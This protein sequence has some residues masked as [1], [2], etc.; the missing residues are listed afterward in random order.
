MKNNQPVNNTERTFSND[1][2]LISTTDLKGQIT[3]VNDAFVEVSGFTR[4]ELIGKPH[5][6]V[7]HP[8]V[9]PA[10]FGDLWE[11]MKA[12]KPWIGIVKNRCKDGSFYWVNAYSTP[13]VE[14]GQTIGYQSVRTVPTKGQVERAERV[15]GRIN[16]G[17]PRLSVHDLSV[18]ARTLIL[19]LC[20][21]SIPMLAGW[22]SGWDSLVMMGTAG[23]SFLIS[24]GVSFRLLA[25]LKFLQARAKRS[26]DSP[27]LEEMYANAVCDVGSI[28]LETMLDHA[29]MVSANARVSY[30]AQDLNRQGDD[31]IGI[32]RQANSAIEQQGR[33]I[34]NVS[35]RIKELSF[36]IQEVA[37][38]ARTTSEETQVASDIANQG[39][40]V[41]GGTIDAINSL[42]ADVERAAQQIESL[43]QATEEIATKTSVITEIADQTNLLAL[44]AA[45]E[46]ARAGEQGRGF[47][48][49]A[50][51]VR[52]LAKRTQLS[53]K[54]IDDT[55]AE[56]QTEATQAMNMMET[57]QSAAR[58]CVDK[59]GDAGE[60]LQNILS[61]VGSIDD[62]STLIASA[63]SQ[64]SAAAEELMNNMTSIQESA[65]IAQ[66]AAQATER[67]S[68]EL[69]ETSKV[70]V[71]SVAV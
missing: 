36:A 55:I 63:S 49:V 12:N 32:A 20:V 56:L 41:V 44:N 34:E 17:R 14:N 31:T 35:E 8:D 18:Q 30:S 1:T 70:I 66:L 61:S 23:L 60:A 21:C 38:H 7:R 42:A 59:A 5:N 43:R 16:S 39:H 28:Y 52:E 47:A 6:V 13:I 46:A 68:V 58:G 65:Q 22:L 10:V 4:E 26:L 11:K 27:V 67:S 2:P 48:V 24:A 54:E 29:R 15:Y 53:T 3:F 9:P 33:D 71:Q 50:D 25:P 64:Q 69:A 57:S 19:L 37:Q 45:I 40:S 62:M 51:E